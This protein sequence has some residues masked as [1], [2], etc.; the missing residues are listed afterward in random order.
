MFKCERCGSRYNA[1]HAAAIESC[2]RCRI[3]DGIDAPLSFSPLEVPRS[4]RDRARI[5]RAPTK[6]PLDGSRSLPLTAAAS[7]PPR[8]EA[9]DEAAARARVEPP[10]VAVGRLALR[11]DGHGRRRRVSGGVACGRGHLDAN[12]PT[13]FQQLAD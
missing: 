5:R 3:R 13:L 8:T 9:L 7:D 10:G 4:M 11:G 1:M 6:I 12:P 2:P